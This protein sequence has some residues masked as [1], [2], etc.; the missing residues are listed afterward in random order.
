MTVMRLKNKVMKVRRLSRD[1]PLL[2]NGD[3]MSAGEFM[4]R[5]ERMPN[6]KKAE[7]IN[8]VVYMASPVSLDL[9]SEPHAH[10]LGVIFNYKIHVP[11]IRIADNGTTKL[12]KKDIPQPDIKLFITSNAGGQSQVVDGYVVGPPELVAEVSA[13]TRSIDINQKF[14][15]YQ[16]AGVKEYLVWRVEDDEIDWWQ[17]IE[18]KYERLPM[19]DA[20]IIRSVV[21]PGLWLNVPELLAENLPAVI[22]TLNVGIASPE[23]RAFVERLNARQSA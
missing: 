5:Y 13:S 16:K 3:E 4:E 11:A 14:Q 18:G 20:G 17:S 8:G 22:A 9:H 1:F 7:L 23:H 19:D 2:E 21:F 6:V 12:G 10:L 15:M